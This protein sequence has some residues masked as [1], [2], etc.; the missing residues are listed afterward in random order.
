MTETPD[1][2][3]EA[4]ERLREALDRIYEIAVEPAETD[5]KS[6]RGWI[7]VEARNA[8]TAPAPRHTSR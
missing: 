7:E 5:D 4:V 6:V 3:P 2:S 8:R 1:T